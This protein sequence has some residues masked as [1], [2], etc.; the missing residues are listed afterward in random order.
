[1]LSSL[2]VSA[3]SAA[4]HVHTLSPPSLLPPPGSSVSPQSKEKGKH[5]VGT[6]P[7]TVPVKRSA[8]G[9]DGEG[10]EEEEKEGDTAGST[11]MRRRRETSHMTGKGH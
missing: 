2:T 8:Q 3:L 6:S 5:R 7:S 1:M 4:L 10:E 9:E 11:A